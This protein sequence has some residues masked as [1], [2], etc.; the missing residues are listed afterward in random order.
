MGGY[1]SKL[2]KVHPQLNTVESNMLLFNIKSSLNLKRMQSIKKVYPLATEIT[3]NCTN[4][5]ATK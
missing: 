1:D 4:E 2:K 5:C 3:S